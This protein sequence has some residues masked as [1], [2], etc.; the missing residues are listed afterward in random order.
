MPTKAVLTVDSSLPLQLRNEC[1]QF[2][3]TLASSA[4][5]PALLAI[6]PSDDL[7]DAKA[8]AVGRAPEGAIEAFEPAAA[9]SD[10][11]MSSAPFLWRDDGRPDW[12]AMWGSF[13]ELALYGGPPHRGE[14]D[15]LGVAP[16]GAAASSDWDAIAEIR[17][18]IW[19]TT[20]LY[21]EPAEPGW[22]AVTCS[23]RKMA[24]WLCAAIILENV[25]ARCEDEVLYLPASPAFDLKDEVKSVITVLAKTHHYWSAHA[26]TTAG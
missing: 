7:A 16:A 9:P 24:A 8:W 20:G 4:G 21:A 17:R 15:A 14:A 23:S 5:E 13:C 18:G 10:A 12:A 1:A 6:L 2:L 3:A 26:A 22:I 19:E 11:S 25:E